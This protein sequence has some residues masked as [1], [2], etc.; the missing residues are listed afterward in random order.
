MVYLSSSSDEE[1]FIPDTSRVEEFA[2]RLFDDLNYDMLGLPGDGMVI[3]LS[4]SDELLVCEETAA[5][6]NVV[7][8]V[9]V[10]SLAPTTS[11]LEMKTPR[12]CK[13]IIVMVLPPIWR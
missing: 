11:G 10:K 2:R 9:V 12:G 13:M 7:P 8:S 1:G 6:A 4:D 5:D 3:V